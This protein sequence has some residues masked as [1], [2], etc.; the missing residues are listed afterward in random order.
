MRTTVSE[1]VV[2]T[3]LCGYLW[4]NGEFSF[5]KAK[6]TRTRVEEGW[7]VGTPLWPNGELEL[8]GVL[9]RLEGDYVGFCPTSGMGLSNLPNSHS[10][11]KKDR[12]VV[13]KFRGSKGLSRYGAKQIRNGCHLIEA[14]SPKLSVSFATVTLP[15]LPDSLHDAVIEQWSQIL[16][17]FFQ[18]VNR[19]LVRAGLPGEVVYVVEPHPRRS[20]AEKR[21]VPHVHFCFQGCLDPY[22]PK[23][24]IAPRQLGK[25]WAESVSCRV[26]ES[27]LF[28]RDA[29]WNITRVVSSVGAYMAKY[30]SKG[31]KKGG[32]DTTGLTER[33]RLTSWFGL[34][35]GIRARVSRAKRRLN[36]SECLALIDS[37][38]DTSIRDSV[39]YYYRDVEIEISGAKLWIGGCGKLRESEC[40]EWQKYLDAARQLD[41][42]SG[43]LML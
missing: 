9:D 26:P 3:Q 36:T 22:S 43:M 42:D 34:I 5:G 6:V 38:K 1:R 17:V 8:E 12:A 27:L 31:A 10:L 4:P 16:R 23:W 19:T 21:L 28:F 41:R 29:H 14:D 7:D 18:R 2:G 25:I 32:M 37:A 30:L 13:E 40:R 33:G 11:L 15:K 24:A 35:G 20:E 39:F